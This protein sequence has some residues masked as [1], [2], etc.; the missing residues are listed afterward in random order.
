[1]NLRDQARFEISL[2]G[3]K[4]FAGSFEFPGGKGG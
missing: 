1:M 3:C 4:E 2:L